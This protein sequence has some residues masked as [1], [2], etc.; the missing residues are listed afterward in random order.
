LDTQLLTDTLGFIHHDA[1][2]LRDDG[3]ISSVYQSF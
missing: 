3:I 1:T 2:S